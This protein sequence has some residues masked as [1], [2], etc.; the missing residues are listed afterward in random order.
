LAFAGGV[1]ITSADPNN[2]AVLIDATVNNSSGLSF[3]NLSL[4]GSSWD[5]LRAFW[6]SKSN[7]IHLD[8]VS[9][10]SVTGLDALRTYGVNITGSTNVS[11]TNSEFQQL[12]RGIVTSTSSNIVLS[13]N[14]VHDIRTDGFDFS[15]VDHVTVSGNVFTSFHPAPGDHPDAIQ[16]FTTGTTAPSHDIAITGNVIL[17]GDGVPMQGIFIRDTDGSLPFTNVTISNNLLYGTHANGITVYYG[18]NLTIDGNELLSPPGKSNE[19]RIIIHTSDHV[20][21]LGNDAVRYIFDQ[22]TNLTEINDTLNQGV[23]DL[24]AAGMQ[25]FFL[26]H[27]DTSPLLAAYLPAV[28]GLP[29]IEGFFSPTPNPLQLDVAAVPD[30]LHVGMPLMPGNFLF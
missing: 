29:P 5:D 3:S 23:T 14:V 24:G 27:P 6:V 22:N 13:G 10:Q 30:L 11:V 9:V 15:Q 19:T 16:F 12:G 1:T 26:L 4:A 18:N 20:T 28:Q 2:K 21:L 25:A 17:V 8:H 7:D